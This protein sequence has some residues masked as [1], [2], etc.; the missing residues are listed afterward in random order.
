MALVTLGIRAKV[1]AGSPEIRRVSVVLAQVNQQNDIEYLTETEF[2]AEAQ[3]ESTT[4]S[5]P[6]SSPIES[7]EPLTDSAAG[8]PIELPQFDAIGLTQ[9]PSSDQGK[10]KQIALSDADR[11]LI[12]EDRA[13]FAAEAAQGSETSIQVFGSGE[14]TGRKFVFVLDRSKS[15]GSQGLG[16]IDK[17]ASILAEAVTALEPNHRFQI[18]AYHHRTTPMTERRLLRATEENKQQVESFI[19][20]LAAFGSTK[21]ESALIVALAMRPDIVVLLT[22]GGLP[23]L[24]RGQLDNIR[25]S[26]GNSTQIHCIQFGAGPR[27]VRGGFMTRIAEENNGSYRYIDVNQWDQ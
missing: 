18:I 20:D 26:A 27:Q 17:A 6:Q 25:R 16:V 12:A 5:L 21:H 10:S 3:A 1:D 23:E 8:N 7:L 13:R 2:E 19:R 15:M 9:V 4:E 24:N 11:E 14:L 22:D